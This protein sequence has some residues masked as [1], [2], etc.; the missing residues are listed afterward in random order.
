MKYNNIKNK[1]VLVRLDLNVPIENGKIVDD[2]RIVSTYQTIDTL[3]KNKNKVIITSHLGEDGESL[4]PVY[5]YLNKKYKDLLFINSIDQKEIANMVDDNFSSASEAHKK[6]LSKAQKESIFNLRNIKKLKTNLIMLENLRCFE[7]EKKNS[8]AFAKFLASIAQVYVYDAFAVAHRKHASVVSVARYLPHCV[9]PLITNELKGL[10]PT[11]KINAKTL[12]ILGG[13]KISTKL[14][15]IDKYLEKGATVF[16]GGAMAHNI[17]LSQGI[18]I[19]LSLYDKDINN[20]TLA[21]KAA[22]KTN[23]L[24]IPYDYITSQNKIGNTS[25]KLTNQA[26]YDLGPETFSMIKKLIEAHKTIIVNGPLGL[27]EK[28]YDKGSLAILRYLASD[29]CKGKVTIAG[30]GDTVE[31]IDKVNL[32]K[33]FTFVSTGGGAMLYYMEKGELPGIVANK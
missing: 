5:K 7:G 12:F 15:L 27:Y 24:Y 2:Y 10:A 16:V 20:K 32:K 31:L 13:A 23:R 19:G 28:G 25:Q 14:P 9:G 26:I 3:L 6:D 17:M 30:G 11:Q 21:K 1:V 29:K 8:A 22:F 4:E 18:S 33:H